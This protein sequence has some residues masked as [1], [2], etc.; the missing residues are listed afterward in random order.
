MANLSE[1]R[2]PFNKVVATISAAVVIL[3]WGWTI[4]DY[5]AWVAFGSG[6]TPPTFRGYLRMT[7]F[8]IQQFFRP[9]NLYDISS[10]SSDG[11]SYLK[12]NLKPR[13]R[14]RPRI[15][16]WT[17]PQRHLPEPIDPQAGI[18]LHT[19]MRAVQSKRPDLLRVAPSK[20]EGGTTDGVYAREDLS[21]LNPVAK[22]K[23]IDHEIAHVHPADN[24]LHVWL[25]GPD[26]KEVIEKGWGQRFVLDYVPEGWTMVYAPRTYNEVD[27]IEEIV[28]AG[29]GWLT[30][31]ILL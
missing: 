6:G 8:R 31:E 23:F 25:S 26:A 5:Y 1:Y 18:R 15:T 4:Q 19:L 10:I 13:G 29:V 14:P 9:R 3:F 12:G 27:V 21:T 20:T 24:S 2:A 11:A 7:K 28:N 22:N 30:R 17:M 16:R